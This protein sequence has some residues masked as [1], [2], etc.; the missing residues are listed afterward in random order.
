[1]KKGI[2][3]ISLLLGGCGADT[4]LTPVPLPLVSETISSPGV[5]TSSGEAM[6]SSENYTSL[7]AVGPYN[8][9]TLEGTWF[10]RINHMEELFDAMLSGGL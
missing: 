2:L 3:I 8:R 5:T 6:M 1:M 4:M 10:R 9:Q 7:V